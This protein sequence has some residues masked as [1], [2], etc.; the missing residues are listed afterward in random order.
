MARH[1]LFFISVD[2]RNHKLNITNFKNKKPIINFCIYYT[3]KEGKLHT[4]SLMSP[5]M[6]DTKCTSSL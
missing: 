1:S 4:N 5:N 6:T 2:Y 3:Q